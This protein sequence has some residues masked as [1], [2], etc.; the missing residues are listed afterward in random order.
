MDESVN[1]SVEIA[2][3]I[4]IAEPIVLDEVA[5]I[6]QYYKAIADF[7]IEGFREVKDGEF[8]T[9]APDVIR[10]LGLEDK[11]SQQNKGE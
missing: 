6:Q 3:P 9:I 11:V 7:Y 5:P 1:E 10:D 8:I 4:A 2:E